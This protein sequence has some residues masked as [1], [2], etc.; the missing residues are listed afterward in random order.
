MVNPMISVIVPVYMVEEYLRQCLDSLIH[1]T[2]KDIE[3]ILVDDGSPDHCGEI[4]EEYAKKDARIIVIHQE[5]GGLS[6]ARNAGLD[7]AKGEYIMFVDSDDWVEPTYC[8]KALKA[9]LEHQVDLAI[10]GFFTTYMNRSV[11]I[12]TPSPRTLDG[13]EAMRHVILNDEPSFCNAV[14]NKIYHRRLFLNIRFPVG[15][16]TEDAAVQYKI[17]HITPKVYVF[18]QCLY[19][20]RKRKYSLAGFVNVKNAKTQYHIF[21][22]LYERLKYIKDHLPEQEL[23]KHQTLELAYKVIANRNRL[24]KA[25]PE[26]KRY[27]DLMTTFLKENKASLLSLPCDRYMR[28]YLCSERLYY[29]YTKLG[30]IKGIVYSWLIPH[31]NKVNN[32]SAISDKEYF[33]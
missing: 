7:I 25:N 12:Q 1:Q 32:S 21:Q 26:E 16:I 33:E 14:W 28:I 24:N 4:C 18:D 11:P 10:M 29:F 3:I 22:I 8:E 9:I 17:L 20:Y 15:M 5:N 13:I 31:K 23:I 27:Y 2:Y 19:H 6:A 30:K